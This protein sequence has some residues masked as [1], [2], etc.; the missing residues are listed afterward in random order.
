MQQLNWRLW[1]LRPPRTARITLCQPHL[2]PRQR[3]PPKMSPRHPPP[4][5]FL[6]L[7]HL[8]IARI[9]SWN[10]PSSLAVHKA[11][12]KVR[13]FCSQ[14]NIVSVWSLFCSTN[15]FFLSCFLIPAKAILIS[16][17]CATLLIAVIILV[18]IKMWVF[19][20]INAKRRSLTQISSIAQKCA[21]CHC[22]T[23]GAC[24]DLFPS[25]CGQK[26]ESHSD[27]WHQTASRIRPDGWPDMCEKH[28]GNHGSSSRWSEDRNGWQCKLKWWDL[29][30]MHSVEIYQV[31][32]F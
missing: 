25:F 10:Q 31:I 6:H 2:P 21:F 4:P 7:P 23:F 17:T 9:M 3:T 28:K 11:F 22:D 29:F 8:L 19:F 20:L 30:K 14:H 27:L 16:S 15:V 12:L 18:Y 32:T 1:Q 24:C 26:I 5:S 13:H